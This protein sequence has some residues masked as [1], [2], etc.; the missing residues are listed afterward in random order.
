[1]GTIIEEKGNLF[2]LNCSLAHCVSSDFKMGAGIAKEF[3]KRFGPIKSKVD[4]GSV[5]VLNDVNLEFYVYYLVTKELYFH[6]PTYKAL[7]TSLQNLREE[8]IR[9]EDKTVGMPRIGCGLDKLDWD[10]VR[11]MIKEVFRDTNITV[12]IRH[13]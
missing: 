7:R 2:D 6:K 9:N 4:I 3:K 5:Y 12:I 1:M 8:L 13:I 10:V 11:D